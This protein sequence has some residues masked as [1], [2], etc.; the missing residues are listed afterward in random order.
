MQNR[1]IDYNHIN[2]NSHDNN[3]NSVPRQASLKHY[4]QFNG[5]STSRPM[6][7]HKSYHVDPHPLQFNH[8]IKST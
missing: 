5:K 6:I 3:I 2:L 7:D 8:G 1:N 4:I